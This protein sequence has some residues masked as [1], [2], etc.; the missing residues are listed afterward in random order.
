MC[1]RREIITRVHAGRLT[2]VF[3]S[4]RRSGM[5]SS[6]AGFFL[7]LLVPG[8][9]SP[10]RQAATADRRA[11]EIISRLELN[12]TDL[13]ADGYD[14]ASPGDRLRRRVPMPDSAP[15]LPAEVSPG[16]N[17]VAVIALEDAMRL[18][19]R[20]NPDYQNRKEAIFRAA[21]SLDVEAEEFRTSWAG[22]LT[23]R[24]SD[25]RSADP[26]AR[27]LSTSA[28]S[29]LSRL[30]S[31]GASVT[32]RLAFDL[33]RLLT[34][35]RDTAYGL[36]ADATITLP[37]L[38]GSSR[39]ILLEPLTMAE[40]RVI[41]A[42]HDF[43]RY[44]R[45][46]AVRVATEYLGALERKQQIANAE[47]NYHRLEISLLRVEK[48]AE[49]G[50]LPA[51]H[52]DQTRQD[53]LRA[54]ERLIAARRGFLRQLDELKRTLGV[55]V[56]VEISLEPEILDRLA[57]ES[58]VPAASANREVSQLP[59]ADRAPVWR[60]MTMEDAMREALDHRLD[61][62]VAQ[63]RVE[64]AVRTVAVAR[65][66]LRGN[67]K[68]EGGAA[69]GGRRD[70]GSVTQGD[71]RINPRRGRYRAVLQLDAPWNRVRE[72]NFYRESMLD[73]AGARR[74]YAEKEDDVRQQVREGLRGLDQARASRL[75][76][77]RAVLLAERRVESTELF[78]QAGRAQVRDVLE[79]QEALVS[80]R[81][82]LLEATVRYLG[83]EWSL[84][85]DMD[86]LRV[87]EF[88]RQFEVAPD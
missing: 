62:R 2:S 81:N 27:G 61:L 33:A 45:A 18:G 39:D 86:V 72:R 20:H 78:L 74:D 47:D 64:D 46:F 48:M 16:T 57:G 87:D 3:L 24:Y 19:A 29:S 71:A 21:L 63:G 34:L 52:V 85:R 67:L 53:L 7:L 76:Q 56:R 6:A 30:F 10:E 60:G 79:A 42:M 1:D 43:E 68:L 75:I 77:Q 12:L 58:A 73:L 9:L 28:E 23:G 26:A 37:L 54:G 40:R 35:D 36:L 80:A 44:R 82:A 69:Y 55:P 84:L 51:T 66:Q 15:D 88:A 41:Y 83:T 5:L 31:T 38:R 70:L 49:A 8:C 14:F 17:G 22:A 65:D 13:G 4:V 50:R 11:R 25:D 32:S 59:M